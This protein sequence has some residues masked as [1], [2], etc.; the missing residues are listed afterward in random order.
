MIF[1]TAGSLEKCE[2]RLGDM[3]FIWRLPFMIIKSPKF[4]NNGY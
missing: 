4:E 3:G 2:C 1:G